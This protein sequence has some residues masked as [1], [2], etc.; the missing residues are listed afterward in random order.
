VPQKLILD[1][2]IVSFVPRSSWR[3]IIYVKKSHF[4]SHRLATANMSQVTWVGS[5]HRFILNICSVSYTNINTKK[6]SNEARYSPMTFFPFLM[7]LLSSGHISFFNGW[8]VKV[9][10]KNLIFVQLFWGLISGLTIEKLAYVI[11]GALVYGVIIIFDEKETIENLGK[12]VS[13]EMVSEGH[14]SQ[15]HSTNL[16]LF[17]EKVTSLVQDHICHSWAFLK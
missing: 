9:A 4:S 7:T 14:S 6:K 15:G 12:H 8:Y 2:K 16:K 1:R 11:C 17:E 3:K 10:S 5:S 13:T